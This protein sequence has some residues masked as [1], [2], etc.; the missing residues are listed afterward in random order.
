MR[1]DTDSCVGRQEYRLI[2]TAGI[3]RR[4]AVASGE[5][6]TEALSVNRAFRAIRRADVVA[7]I[8]DAMTC[9]TEQV[10]GWQQQTGGSWET[11]LCSLGWTGG[12]ERHGG[13]WK[14][15]HV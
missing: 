13:R 2:D 7:L 6:K 12:R 8:I 4:G 10:G 11:W 9:V 1:T 14:Y 15:V 3:R 5:S